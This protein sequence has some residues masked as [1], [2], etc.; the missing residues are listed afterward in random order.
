M[1]ITLRPRARGTLCICVALCWA[2]SAATLGQSP[3]TM[4]GNLSDFK[5]L[6][7]QI[8]VQG[9]HA[10][11]AHQLDNFANA[12]SPGP[13]GFCDD[14]L[15]ETACPPSGNLFQM[16]SPTNVGDLYL[17][18]KP[19]SDG[20]V[21]PPSADD[22]WLAVGVNI[23]NGDG[24]VATNGPLAC[25]ARGPLPLQAP[26]LPSS[27]IDPTDPS[28]RPWLMVPFDD[29]G[30]GDPGRLGLG[31]A[32]RWYP[33]DPVDSFDEVKD[34]IVLAFRF[35]QTRGAQLEDDRGA[36][37][38]EF[39]YSQQFD[40]PT[41]MQVFVKGVEIFPFTNF[42]SIQAFPPIGEAA[43]PVIMDGGDG[44]S[45]TQAVGDD[46]QVIPKF[47]PVRAP[48][49][50]I[51]P[52]PNG[53]INTVPGGDD[54]LTTT[55]PITQRGLQPDF[56]FPDGLSN[57]DIEVYVPK[58]DSAITKALLPAGQTIQQYYASRI[59]NVMATV[60]LS[61]RSE[62]SADL[63]T[64]D[65][66]ST[67]A[68][69]VI[70]GLEATKEVRCV[71]TGDPNPWSTSVRAL[72]GSAVEFKVSVEN[73]SNVP[74]A[75][76]LT[77]VLQTFGSA[78][79]TVNPAFLQATLFRPSNGA[80]QAITPANAA[81]FGLNTGF[82]TPGG[83]GSPGFLGGIPSGLPRNAGIL[84]GVQACA[85]VPAPGD[86]LELVFRATFTTPDCNGSLAVD[87]KN[88]IAASG[89]DPNAPSV[90]LVTDVPGLV[91][92]DPG[93]GI[94]TQRERAQGFDDNVVE[95]NLLLAGDVNC[96]CLV[97]YADINPFVLA[98]SSLSAWQAQYPS[99]PWQ[100]CD[101]NGDGVVSYADINP[102]VLV[103]AGGA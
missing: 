54:V 2:G 72:P 67:F 22:S 56:S 37:D 42:A 71:Q 74:L 89:A 32:S 58:I 75:V 50:I 1:I 60:R 65:T 86:R 76:T 47:S 51:L 83:P 91:P 4:D 103:L 45:S 27:T 96:D 6:V 90:T 8:Q 3:P 64:E 18:Y 41:V 88:S 38:F 40:F 25:T 66:M 39:Y 12:V 100:N 80:G 13:Q 43:I 17:V 78:G 52:G 69:L 102:F 97:S 30:N 93:N 85:A 29:D 57:N 46:I 34:T 49:V 36:P 24:D 10:V 68:D 19:D 79:F 82:F 87:A 23:A 48:G 99:C 77:D 16:Y 26:I 59:R 28:H 55:S 5:A 61:L 63:S 62:S 14:I 94:D 35:C 15:N 31:P 44:F 101:I 11:G 95:I 98:L 81:S 21:D 84:Q 53:V 9:L 73:T 92:A 33:N 70:P 7:Q 20:V